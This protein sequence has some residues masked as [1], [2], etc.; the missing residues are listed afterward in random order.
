MRVSSMEIND[1]R[2]VITASFGATSWVPGSSADP[3]ALILL[4]G[5]IALSALL[6]LLVF[7]LGTG[8]M[9]AL[10]LVREKARELG[11]KPKARFVSYATAGVAPEI[12]GAARAFLVGG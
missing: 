11:L 5:G 2:S 7:V 4:I 1:S 9:R 3:E 6:G 12:M 8:R 10:S